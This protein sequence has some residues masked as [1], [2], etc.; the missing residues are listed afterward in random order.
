MVLCVSVQVF[1]TK[2]SKDS[3]KLL[4]LVTQVFLHDLT[5][6]LFI[7]VYFVHDFVVNVLEIVIELRSAVLYELFVVLILLIMR[8]CVLVVKINSVIHINRL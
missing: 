6:G 4:L 5:V 1:I 2:A 8:A 7:F 3:P